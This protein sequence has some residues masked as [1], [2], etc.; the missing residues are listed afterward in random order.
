MGESGNS[1]EEIFLP[2]GSRQFKQLRDRFDFR[3]K[4]AA[5]FGPATGAAERFVKRGVAEATVFVETN[6]E[7]VESRLALADVARAEVRLA[8]FTATAI[9]DGA[10]DVAYAQASIGDDRREDIL[11]E[12]R[13]LLA[14][15][16]V[17][18]VGDVVALRDDSPPFVS[19]LWKRA[20]L[21]PLPHNG[22]VTFFTDRGFEKIEADFSGDGLANYYRRSRTK[23]AEF[24]ETVEPAEAKLLKKVFARAKR[25]ADAFLDHGGDKFATFALGVFKKSS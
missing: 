2:G 15:D 14:E 18:S 5:I 17:L 21:R 25:E 1:G 8:S 23:L 24:K 10:F 11:K 13:R 16:G 4:R 12:I 19:D 9:D 6:E 3:G 22:F 7:L 20:G